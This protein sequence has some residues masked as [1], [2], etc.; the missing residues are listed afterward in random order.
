MNQNNQPK[1]TLLKDEEWTIVENK[2]CRIFDFSPLTATFSK[3]YASIIFEC[4]GMTREIKG[5]ITNKI[6]F[7][8]LQKAFNEDIVK[9]GLEKGDVEILIF[10]TRTNYRNFL[11]KSL[12]LF[13]PK[14]I[15]LICKKGSF[16]LMTDSNYNPQLKGMARFLEERPIIEFKPEVMR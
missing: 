12:S 4:R 14:L 16:E 7:A 2:I 10:W 11:F 5:F 1:L 8:N 6:D 13:M 15:V 3:P 9:K